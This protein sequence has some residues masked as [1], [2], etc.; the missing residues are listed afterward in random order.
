MALL[1]RRRGGVARVT[2]WRGLATACL[3]RSGSVGMTPSC[4]PVA[5]MSRAVVTKRVL[6]ALGAASVGGALV[7]RS[8]VYYVR[9]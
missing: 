5:H 4:M 9:I 7:G 8:D 2:S 6:R 3:N 1:G